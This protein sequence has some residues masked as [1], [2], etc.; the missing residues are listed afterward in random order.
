LETARYSNYARGFNDAR[1]ISPKSRTLDNK[2][3]IS[4]RALDFSTILNRANIEMDV[5]NISPF[6]NLDNLML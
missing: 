3:I 4:P 1:P 5:E 2:S 6:E